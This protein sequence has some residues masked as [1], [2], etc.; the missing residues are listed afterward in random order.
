MHV[1]SVDAV[2]VFDIHTL[3]ECLHLLPAPSCLQAFS[4]VNEDAEAMLRADPAVDMGGRRSHNP[5]DAFPDRGYHS[6]YYG[7]RPAMGHPALSNGKGHHL[8][9]R[10]NAEVGGGCTWAPPRV[11]FCVLLFCA[12]VH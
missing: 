9:A 2:I 8:A 7:G 11:V 12:V 5:Y 3:P 6:G 10:Q 1:Q 4:A